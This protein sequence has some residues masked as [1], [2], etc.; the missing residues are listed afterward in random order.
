MDTKKAKRIHNNTCAM[1]VSVYQTHYYSDSPSY[2]TAP[3]SINLHFSIR[4]TDSNILLLLNNKF[5][6]SL[7]FK[8][9]NESLI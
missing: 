2:I 4:I 3:L 1:Q 7:Y 5:T 8:L 6:H 9:T